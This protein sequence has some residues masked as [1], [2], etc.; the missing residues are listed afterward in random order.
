MM[1]SQRQSNSPPVVSKA[2][3]GPDLLESLQVLPQLVVQL[4]GQQ[5]RV[6]SVSY[7][8]LPVHKPVR[9]LVLPRVLHDGYDPLN[10]ERVTPGEMLVIYAC[11][12]VP[13]SSSDSSPALFLM[14]TSA[15]LQTRLAYRL[16]TP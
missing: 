14:S 8:L 7:I 5:L 12:V 6:F 3:M 13:T 2:A 10:L 11:L 15:F 4:V 16:P 9:D 1:L